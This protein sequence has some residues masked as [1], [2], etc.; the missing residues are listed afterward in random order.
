MIYY[1]TK[2]ARYLE[3]DRLINRLPVK[4]HQDNVSQNVKFSVQFL[5]KLDP[6][7]YHLIKTWCE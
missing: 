3:G 5:F 4:R 2:Q 1:K 7:L 6:E